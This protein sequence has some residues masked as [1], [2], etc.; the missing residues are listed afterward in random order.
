[1]VDPLICF[2]AEARDGPHAPAAKSSNEFKLSG[3]VSIGF[4]SLSV[5]D[6]VVAGTRPRRLSEIGHIDSGVGDAKRQSWS[7]ATCWLPKAGFSAGYQR[8]RQSGLDLA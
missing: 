6:R 7:Q 5:R 1:M 2:P 4:S 3:V 8:C